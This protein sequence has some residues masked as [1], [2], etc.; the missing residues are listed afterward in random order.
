MCR[1]LDGE[2]ICREL[3]GEGICWG[4]DR[5]GICRGLDRE[6]YVGDWIERDMSGIRSCVGVFTTLGGARGGGE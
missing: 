4:L 3:N 6:G 5:E 1:G 2:G